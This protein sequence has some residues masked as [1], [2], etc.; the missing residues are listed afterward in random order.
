MTI[1]KVCILTLGLLSTVSGNFELC[2][3]FCVM[4]NHSYVLK[5]G[6]APDVRGV[7][8]TDEQTLII[9]NK[10]RTIWSDPYKYYDDLSPLSDISPG[11]NTR[12]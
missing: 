9:R 8:W 6:L 7:Q 11:A 10:I 3:Y 2:F 12:I 4:V 5:T 1:D